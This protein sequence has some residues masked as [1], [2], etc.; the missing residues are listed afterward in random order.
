MGKIKESSK[1]YSGELVSTIQVTDQL[2]H[3]RQ[4]S[5]GLVL[6]T[7]QASVREGREVRNA[8][9]AKMPILLKHFNIDEADPKKWELLSFELAIRHVPGFQFKIKKGRPIKSTHELLSRLYYFYNKV[10]PELG[11]KTDSEFC[12]HIRKK[13]SFKTTFPELADINKKNLQNI[14]AEAK[15]LPEDLRFP[16]HP[17]PMF[18]KYGKK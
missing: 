18:I 2:K 6:R 16:E 13:T 4:A 17:S 1:E 8:R 15:K 14:L 12:G 7:H 10:K 11:Y 9:L 3:Q 5:S